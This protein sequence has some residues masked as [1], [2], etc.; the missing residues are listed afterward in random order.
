[1]KSP[2]VGI[3]H[4]AIEID[5]QVEK[6]KIT[7]L[8]NVCMFTLLKTFLSHYCANLIQIRSDRNYN[9]LPQKLYELEIGCP[10]DS[11]CE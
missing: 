6:F 3:T 10:V 4:L 1:M 9:N 7:L 5:T 8:L 11:R 2:K